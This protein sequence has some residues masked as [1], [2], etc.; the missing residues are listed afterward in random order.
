VREVAVNTSRTAILVLF[1]I[2]AGH[3]LPAQRA[4]VSVP[5]PSIHPGWNRGFGLQRADGGLW[6]VGPA[7]KARFTAAGIEFTTVLGPAAPRSFPLSFSLESVRRGD[8]LIYE[9]PP[10]GI[11]PIE[12]GLVAR[13][14]RGAFVETY[15]VRREGIEQS[16]RF[17]SLPRG[18]GDLLVR[19]RIATDLFAPAVDG[20][21]DGIRFEVGD[22]GGVSF[23]TVIGIDAEGHRAEG[24]LRF[25]GTYL[26]LVLPGSFVDEAVFPLLLDPLIGPTITIS[27]GYDLDPD[28][29]YD[30]SAGIYLVV[31]ERTIAATVHDVMGQ[32]FSTTGAPVGAP[33]PI[34]TSLFSALDPAVANVAASD[35]FLVVWRYVSPSGMTLQMRAVDA[36]NGST[37]NLLN[38]PDIGVT[39]VD[40]GGYSGSDPLYATT[41]VVVYSDWTGIRHRQVNVPPSGSIAATLASSITMDPNDKAPAVTKHGGLAGRFLVVWDRPTFSNGSRDIYYQIVSIGAPPLG[42]GSQL[43]VTLSDEE[44]ADCAAMDDSNFM[45]VYEK[46]PGGTTGHNDIACRALYLPPSG[47]GLVSNETLLASG[48]SYDQVSPTVDFAQSKYLV[49]YASKFSPLASLSYDLFVL[50]VDP[51]GCVPCEPAVAVDTLTSTQANFPKIAANYSTGF[52]TAAA[53]QAMLVWESVSPTDADVKAQRLEAIG[54]GGAV[55]DL[56]GG[57][58]AGGTITVNGPVALGNSSFAYGLSGAAGP[59]VA[60]VLSPTLANFSCGPCTLRPGFDVILAVPAPFLSPTPC[61]LALY[62]ATLYAQWIVATPGGC[63]IAPPLALSSA[64]SVTIGT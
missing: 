19:G 9:A 3:A 17:D 16:F 56:G 30:A 40:V 49:A 4:G 1:A 20:A 23:G 61:N 13:Y 59:P 62:G 29:A 15:E 41:A 48:S 10:E 11:A 44:N 2:S 21:S 32:R 47:T 38:L 55:V 14:E 27:G 54:A 33:F 5:E 42:S 24:W 6:A 58:G 53:D 39:G 45:V 12:E 25:D 51:N 22:L 50:G 60:L 18:T 52:S 28:V 34:V 36:S 46:Q 26:D 8:A 43:T 64:I 63:P 31:W 35:R 57:C 37:S 7:Y